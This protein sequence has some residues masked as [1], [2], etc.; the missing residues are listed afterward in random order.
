MTTTGTAVFFDGLTS[1]RQD[2]HV[3]LE[4]ELFILRAD[5]A[6]VDAWPY[7][8]LRELS[9][10]DGV[11]RLTREGG[12]PLARLEIRDAGLAGQIRDW[13]P[14][15][16]KSRATE[17]GT[18]RKVV[19]W[20]V[21]AVV[22]LTVF[23]FFG[24]P[25]IAAAVTPMLPWGVDQKMGENAHAQLQAILP[26][27][28]GSFACGEGSEEKP[29]RDALDRL[30]KKLSDAA[31]LPVPIKIYAVRS[32]MVNALALPGSPIYLF[33]GLIENSISG[34]EVA[35]VLA[36]EIGHVA[37][38]DG[39]R[40]ALAAG[41]TSLVL[42]FVI[43]DFVGGA[44]AIAVAQAVNEASYSRDA[45]RQADLYAVQ[46]MKRLGAD[47]KAVGTLLTRLTAKD[48]EDGKSAEGEASGDA[49]DKP[50]EKTEAKPKDQPE[51]AKTDVAGKP[52]KTGDKKAGERDAGSIMDWLSSHP[53]T[54]ERQR[55]ID[56]AAGDGPTTPAMDQ[57]DYLALKRICGQ[58]K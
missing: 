7:D 3:S 48:R 41:G 32:D 27:R 19:F 5:G 17:A 37:N 30:A 44:A 23:S 13:S 52:D 46:L 58:A 53:D 31:G 34:D 20:S 36:H 2:V 29:G 14:E 55:V 28:G 50:Q 26:T 47:G 54:A 8:D 33:D 1:R 49:K 22:S 10:P 9:A 35:G 24:I 15:L 39:T 4:H 51:E 16:G 40:H 42:G 38:R 11:L 57:A 18:T 43:G 45:E 56:A 12:P 25:R 6:R 21:F